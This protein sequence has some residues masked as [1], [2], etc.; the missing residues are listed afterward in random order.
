MNDAVVQIVMPVYNAAGTLPRA[1]DSLQAQTFQK[2]ECIVVDDGSIDD[3]PAILKHYQN[4]DKR[5]R[6]VSKQHAGIVQALN[7][8]L[9]RCSAPFVARMDAD[10][11]SLPRRLE[12]QL[13][14]L[15]S[16]PGIGVASCLVKHGQTHKT[17][18]GYNLYVEWTN[19][20]IT[21]EAHYLNRFI[22]SPLAHPTVMFRGELIERSGGYREHPCW[23]EDYELWLRWM[24]A[25]VTFAKVPEILYHWTDYPER[26]SRTD[27]RYSTEAFYACKTAYLAKGPLA[28]A[29]TVGIWGAG[30]ITRK[31]A[32]LLESYGYTIQFYVDIDPDKIGRQV[33]GVPV[34]APETLAQMP[35]IPLLAYVGS[36]GARE[37]IRR[38][39]KDTR[40]IEGV[41]FWCVA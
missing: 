10:D 39:L 5:F 32:A 35:D 38:R 21:P 27:Q 25:G 29:T 41:N 12:Q 8:G 33:C 22:E 23:P 9:D 24:Q 26:L 15:D 36:R 34:L 13:A 11:E 17:Q 7:T 40:Y 19:A 2:W 3:S 1:L 20:I 30:R 6:V 16:H 28:H 37:A 14:L 18:R 31:R 4:R